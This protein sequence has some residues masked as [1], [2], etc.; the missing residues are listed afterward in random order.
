[1]P[2]GATAVSGIVVGVDGS[3][4]SR[5]A[6]KWAVAEAARRATTITAVS[7]WEPSRSAGSVRRL[8]PDDDESIARAALAAETTALASA[9]LP[10]ASELVKGKP[11]KVLT[12]ASADAEL[13]VVGSSAHGRRLGSVAL[14]C[15]REAK[16][17]VVVV[18]T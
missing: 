5:E 15:V 6:L 12:G 11:T 3:E 2:V 17:S 1:M 16:C 8:P 18:R 10:I 9:D 14:H 13:L 7:A 4:G